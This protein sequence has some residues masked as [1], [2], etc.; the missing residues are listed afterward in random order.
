MDAERIERALREGP[1]DEPIYRPG[2][3]REQRRPWLVLLAAGTVL[4]IALVVGV[5]AGL[6]VDVLRGPSA[7]VGGPLDVNRLA[8]ELEG[9]W[10][11]DDISREEWIQEL[12]DMG[13]RQADIDF[14][15]SNLPAHERVRY[16]L[17]FQEEHLQIFGSFDGGELEPM[18]GGPYQLLPNGALYYDD[19][20]CFITVLFDIDGDRLAFEPMAT[21]GCS[22]D[23]SLNNAA[24]FNLLTYERATP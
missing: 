12:S 16:D 11:S 19:V 18:S 9:R 13:Y 14:A 1:P 4:G 21:D 7:G 17:V 22:A 10:S 3:F 24:Y 5:V 2:A 20:A 8:A 15:L 6:A 23:E